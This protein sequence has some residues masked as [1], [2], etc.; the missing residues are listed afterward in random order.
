MLHFLIV[1]FRGDFL[2]PP[3][4]QWID[5]PVS[6]NPLY[7]DYTRLVRADDRVF[8]LQCPT[9]QNSS[10]ILMNY[11]DIKLVSRP[12]RWRATSRLSISA[13]VI[14]PLFQWILSLSRNP[15]PHTPRREG[16]FGASGNRK[17][18]KS[19]AAAAAACR[20]YYTRRPSEGPVKKGCRRSLFLLYIQTKK[21]NETRKRR[22]RNES[23]GLRAKTSAVASFALIIATSCN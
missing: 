3:R 12:Q 10:R 13:D 19:R 9:A 8:M 15:F 2:N 4:R 23:E 7:T 5:P 22:R 1:L 14:H 21:R 17:V 18:P 16:Q 6:A 20:D 11:T